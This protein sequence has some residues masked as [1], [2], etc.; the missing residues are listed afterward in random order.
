MVIKNP[1]KIIARY[2]SYLLNRPIIRNL[3]PESWYL[4]VRYYFYIEKK[5]DLTNPITYNE[6]LQWL[7]LN[8]KNPR[9]TQLADKYEV[10]DYIKKKIGE[11]HLIPLV[12][13]P[14]NNFDEIDFDK[15]PNQFVLKTT[16]DSGG[17]VICKEKNEFNIK[18][19][20]EKIN[21][22]LKRKFYWIGREWSYKKI[23]P[24]IIAEKYMVDESG[25][26]LKDYKIFCFNGIPKLIQV[27]FGRFSEHKRNF[28]SPDWKYLGFTT[29]IY[30]TDPDINI[31]RPEKLDY[32]LSI[33]KK[34]SKGLPHVR[35]DL[36]SIYD[37]IYFGELT[38]Y[39]GSGF[40]KFNPE[41]WDKTIGELLELQKNNE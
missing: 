34:L 31:Q 23:S 41:E 36:Y 7:K 5:L 21:E 39:H 19:A 18:N 30:P 8:Y 26:E 11:N 15:L 6:K 33:S 13:G 38:F 29:N 32:M 12:G 22:H 4:K 16:H 28:Y 37:E 10:R 25:Y 9:L 1:W 17:V 3:T 27:D 20:K 14:W 35:V 40:E 2:T 24:R